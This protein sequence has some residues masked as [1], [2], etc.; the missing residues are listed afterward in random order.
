MKILEKD[1]KRMF[2]LVLTG[3][4]GAGTASIMKNKDKA[5]ARFVAGLKLNNSNLNLNKH[6]F[7][8]DYFWGTFSEFGNKA[9]ELGATLEDVQEV[10]NTNQVPK[11]YTEQLIKLSGK[12]LRD[13]FVGDLSKKILDAGFDINFLPCNGWA[14]TEVG[15]DAMERNGRKWT[16]GYKCEI[17]LGDKKVNLTFDAITDEGDGPTSF[18]IYHGGSS[19]LFN[20]ISGYDKFGKLNF[21]SMIMNKLNE[22]VKI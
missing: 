4:D 22:S 7:R 14:I 19:N 16:I 18:V 5:I 3:K 12:K 10:Y 13:R 1:W 6:I 17:D 9:I 8:N 11:K 15:K 21:M 2:D 20:S